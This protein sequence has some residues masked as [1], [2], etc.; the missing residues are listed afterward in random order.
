MWRQK[1]TL[2]IMTPSGPVEAFS[3]I[4]VSYVDTAGTFTVPE[5]RGVT[6]GVTGEAVVADLGG[7]RYLFALL[8]GSPGGPQGQTRE[9]FR[10]A[11]DA[12]RDQGYGAWIK[13]LKSSGG[14][15]ELPLHAY[16]MLVGFKDIS[17]PF[18]VFEVDP[19]N[20]DAAFGEGYALDRMSLKITRQPVTTGSVYSVL[21]W[22]RDRQENLRPSA[23][24]FESDVLPIEKIGRPSFVQ[25]I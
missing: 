15:R 16:P 11:Y 18:S 22:L 19:E 14:P 17:D 23:A 20:L 21:P 12:H 1:L 8:T 4:E 3:V 13:K 25:G 6:A 10:D 2:H 9:T 24:K 7:G 5:A